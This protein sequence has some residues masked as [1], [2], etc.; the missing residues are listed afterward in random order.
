MRLALSPCPPPETL[1]QVPVSPMASS[2]ADNLIEAT[3]ITRVSMRSC[4][5]PIPDEP[6]I[7]LSP[8]LRKPHVK[9]I[10][11]QQTKRSLNGR[12][13]SSGISLHSK[14]AEPTEG[15]S[16]NCRS[17]RSADCCGAL[18]TKVSSLLLVP[19]IICGERRQRFIGHKTVWFQPCI[20]KHCFY[21]QRIKRWKHGINS[22][23][24]LCQD[25]EKSI[26]NLFFS[27]TY[28]RGIWNLILQLD[29]EGR[30]CGTWNY[31]VI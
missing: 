20:R 6:I 9:S 10:L 4:G 2:G 5:I 28:S 14:V 15:N 27:R 31:E 30:A 26:E 23:C 24:V 7:R 17:S 3:S 25:E 12:P 1:A 18:T 13:M 29:E 19:G 21:E 16:W 11:I 22:T 8:G